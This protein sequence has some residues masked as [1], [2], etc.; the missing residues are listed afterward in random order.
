[1][2]LS[3]SSNPVLGNIRWGLWF[4]L[5]YAVIY[6]LFVTAMAILRG[7]TEYPD[8][9]LNTWIIIATYF[10]LGLVGG[11]TIGLLRPLLRWGLGAA[12]V[13]FV[14]G[15][16]IFLGI[17]VAQDGWSRGVLN[18]ALILG[19]L[20]GPLTAFLIRRQAKHLEQRHN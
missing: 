9:G 8:Q 7:S 1:M 3:P 12:F 5:W 14:I 19:A 18:K 2:S 17:G 13:G 10:A 20:S 16:I 11:V 4:G 6:S 15:T